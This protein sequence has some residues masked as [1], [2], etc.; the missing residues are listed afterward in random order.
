MG[1]EGHSIAQL[2]SIMNKNIGLQHL[3]YAIPTIV[4]LM[5]VTPPSNYFLLTYPVYYKLLLFLESKNIQPP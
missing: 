5:L 1:K 2:S 3:P 4:I